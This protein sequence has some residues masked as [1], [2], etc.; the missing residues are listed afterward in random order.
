M[1]DVMLEVKGRYVRYNE[2][3]PEMRDLQS[4]GLG[5]MEQEDFA[6]F[7]RGLKVEYMLPQQPNT[8]RVFKVNGVRAPCSEYR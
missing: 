6:K 5:R 3:P 8:R 7:I 2:P 1:L 4:K